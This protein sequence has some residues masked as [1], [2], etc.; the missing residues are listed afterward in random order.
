ML[1]DCL[2]DDE[3]FVF[4]YDSDAWK[5]RNSKRNDVSEASSA[6]QLSMDGSK[7]F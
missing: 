1:C 6:S 3:L 2:H 7:Q 4:K 5:W